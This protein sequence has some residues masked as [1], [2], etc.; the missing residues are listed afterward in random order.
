MLPSNHYA[1]TA[2]A[3]GNISIWLQSAAAYISLTP[4]WPFLC[5]V[6]AELSALSTTAAALTTYTAA[7]LIAYLALNLSCCSC[8]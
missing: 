1:E 2:A 8:Y 3:N 6:S 5:T 7:Y 4:H